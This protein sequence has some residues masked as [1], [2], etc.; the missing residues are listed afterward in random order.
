[1]A[2]ASKTWGGMG[3]ALEPPQREAAYFFG[4]FLRGHSL[5]KLRRDID[6]PGDVLGRWQKLWHRQPHTRRELETILQYRRQV[7]TIFNSLVRLDVTF[8]HWR[9]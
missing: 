7:L 2:A 3:E 9:Q 8:S 1:M 6:V 5:E 4:L